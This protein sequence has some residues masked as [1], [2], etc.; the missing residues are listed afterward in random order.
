[1]SFFLGNS[2]QFYQKNDFMWLDY[3]PETEL[4]VKLLVIRELQ[5]PQKAVTFH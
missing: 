2:I 1:M 3:N 4:G 5:L